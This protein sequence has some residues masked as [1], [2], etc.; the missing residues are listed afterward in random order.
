MP[1][2]D[3]LYK[4][5]VLQYECAINITT[6]IQK[7]IPRPLKFS[8]C[9]KSRHAYKSPIKDDFF[10]VMDMYNF[11]CLDENAY[12]GGSVSSY[13]YKYVRFILGACMNSTLNNN[14]CAPI[15]VQAKYLSGVY[16]T[17]VYPDVNIDFQNYD[18]PI[19][20]TLHQTYLPVSV[21]SARIGIVNYKENILLTN[22][23]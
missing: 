6:G 10:L 17:G 16:I 21:G 9:N 2:N 23:G 8:K 14:S 18:N 5:T 1:Y 12:F 13:Y 3:A 22:K 7:C 20:Q 15:T 11:F 19:E 4:F